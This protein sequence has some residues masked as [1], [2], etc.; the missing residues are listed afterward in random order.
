MSV[1]TTY[2]AYIVELCQTGNLHLTG[3]VSHRMFYRWGMFY[4]IWLLF[5]LKSID[6]HECKPWI[7]EIYVH[8]MLCE[9]YTKS[10][11]YVRTACRQPS[12]T[13]GTHYCSAVWHMWDSN[14]AM[15]R[16]LGLRS[17]K[18]QST[19]MHLDQQKIKMIKTM[20][21]LNKYIKVMRND[22]ETYYLDSVLFIVYGDTNI[23]QLT[24]LLIGP[25]W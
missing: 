21:K 9:R 2:Y 18:H 17:I 11:W 15:K 12:N 3:Q 6:W 5:G 4:Q 25:I 8:Q 19:I 16:W 14:C 10:S 23:G 20:I 13:S 7:T 1:N 24:S 22:H